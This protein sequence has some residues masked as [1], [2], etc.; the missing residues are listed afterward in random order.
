LPAVNV[1]LSVSRVESAAQA[2]AMQEI[3]ESLKL[4]L[5]QYREIETFASFSSDLD[6]TTLRILERGARLVEFLKQDKYS[7]L[8]LELQLVLLY[9]AMFG[10]LDLLPVSQIKLFERFVEFIITRVP[11]YRFI[12]AK[13]EPYKGIAPGLIAPFLTEVAFLYSRRMTATAR[14]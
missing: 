2:I 1:G 5:A 10:Y 8:L 14:G 11:G 12:L 7:P 13:M 9:A 4:E 6:Q 3:V